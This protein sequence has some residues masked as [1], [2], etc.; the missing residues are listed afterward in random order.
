MLPN[1]VLSSD[2]W[3]QYLN[4]TNKYHITIMEHPAGWNAHNLHE[5]WYVQKITKEE[6]QE[7]LRRSSIRT[8][9][10]SDLKKKGLQGYEYHA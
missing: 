5:E 2:Q 4:N 7:R 1:V 10:K 6:F 3:F 8:E 9:R